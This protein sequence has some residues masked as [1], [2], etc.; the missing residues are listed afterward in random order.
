MKDA[1]AR[2][3]GLDD[4]LRSLPN[5]N[6]SLNLQ[7][8]EDKTRDYLKNFFTCSVGFFF[9]KFADYIAIFVM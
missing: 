9:S 5:L 2:W 8:Y 6:H 7:R 1:P 3:F 4:L